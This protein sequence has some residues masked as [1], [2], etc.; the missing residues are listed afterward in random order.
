MPEEIENLNDLSDLGDL[1]PQIEDLKKEDD[2]NNN[3][4]DNVETVNSKDNKNIID[5]VESNKDDNDEI[6]VDDNVESYV[7][8]LIANIGYTIKDEKG[9]VIKYEDTSEGLQNYISDVINSVKKDTELQIKESIIKEINPQAVKLDLHLKAGGTLETFFTPLNINIANIKLTENNIDDAKN[10]IKV[11]LERLGVNSKI[12]DV[13]LKGLESS[14]ELLEEAKKHQKAL[15]DYEK[16]ENDKKLENI[17]IV[18]QKEKED[19]ENYAANINKLIDSRNI[20][21]ISL[22]LKEI[23]TFKDYIFKL[24]D[25]GKTQYDLDLE[26][27]NDE[28]DLFIAYLKFKKY[29]FSKI[30]LEKQNSKAVAD[31]K[32]F[33]NKNT[34]SKSF[35]NLRDDKKNI[36]EDFWSKV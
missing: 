25:N 35:E 23:P 15:L 16:S 12:I 6:V 27:D 5:D 17:K 28:H 34:I 1:L 9:E 36:D 2:T 24:N 7:D 19:I 31:W 29:D 21:G 13:T 33:K 3:L 32:N 22:D 10:V 20:N 26:Q 30:I 4:D 11:D 8:S 14:G 18:K